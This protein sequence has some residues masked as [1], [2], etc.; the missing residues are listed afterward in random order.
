MKN[1]LLTFVVFTAFIFCLSTKLY[2]QNSS[3]DS[4]KQQFDS[5]TQIPDLSKQPSELAGQP[6][7]LQQQPAKAGIHP[8]NVN[9]WLSGSIALAGG[10]ANFLGIPSLL[11]KQN[12]SALEIQNLNRDIIRGFDRWALNLDPSNTAI[13]T[14][15]GDVTMDLCLAAPAALAFNKKV[16]QDWGKMLIMYLETMS[17]TSD[18]YTISFLGPH[19]QNKFRPVVYYEAV[20][21][22]TKLDGNNRNS[23][24]SGHAAATAAATFFLTK[25][26]C[27]YH[28]DLG[29]KKYLLYIAA[30]IPPLLCGY[31][32]VMSLRHFPSD[33][34][35]G[36]GIGAVCGILIPEIHLIKL[37][38]KDM[39]LGLST[40]GGVAGVGLTWRPG[41]GSGK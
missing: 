23:F 11:H 29:G 17:L 19:Y 15:L 1:H 18:V 27:D 41:S 24:Y 35:A 2:S 14:T 7:N 9:I 38:N 13:Y 30:S 3:P 12:I 37:K 22:A 5:T 20:P 4:T 34:M 10:V 25:V 40:S 21:Y 36:F 31:F 26:Y 16:K 39:A 28:P 33:V 32:R 6:S 8:Y